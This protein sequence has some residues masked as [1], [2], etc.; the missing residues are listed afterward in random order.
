MSPAWACSC[1]HR[2]SLAAGGRKGR[3]ALGGYP[4]QHLTGSLPAS[5]LLLALAIEPRLVTIDS[6]HERAPL[7]KNCVAR[8]GSNNHSDGQ[9]PPHSARRKKSYMEKAASAKI[10][11]GSLNREGA[12]LLACQCLRG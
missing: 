9:S 12:R 2:A 7:I 1:F 8:A 11:S 3:F 6:G 10:A 5:D 4:V